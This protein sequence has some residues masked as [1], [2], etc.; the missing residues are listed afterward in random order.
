[1]RGSPRGGA[2]P[3]P[4]ESGA[5]RPYFF[6]T[7]TVKQPQWARAALGL[8]FGCNPERRPVA[9]EQLQQWL[10]AEEETT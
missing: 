7:T 10:F 4:Y 3:Y 5:V 6:Q 9:G 2:A 8:S 1:M